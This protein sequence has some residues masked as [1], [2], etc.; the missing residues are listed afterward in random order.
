MIY[1]YALHRYMIVK[2]IS[3]FQRIEVKEAVEQIKS[4]V[5]DEVQTLT[6]SATTKNIDTIHKDPTKYNY[7]IGSIAVDYLAI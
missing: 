2:L 4:I 1:D 7:M 5:T 3:P 6:N